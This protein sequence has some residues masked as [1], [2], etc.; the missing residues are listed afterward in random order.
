MRNIFYISYFL[1]PLLLFSCKKETRIEGAVNQSHKLTIAEARNHIKATLPTNRVALARTSQEKTDST[2]LVVNWTAAGQNTSGEYSF[3]EVPIKTEITNVN[4]YGAKQY[5]ENE[6][7]TR[8][9]YSYSTLLIY[10]DSSN[11][12]ASSYIVT[13]LPSIEYIQKHNRPIGRNRI[14]DLSNEFS[15]YIEY[16]DLDGNPK[17][18][19][20]I[21]KGNVTSSMILSNTRP[22]QTKTSSNSKSLAAAA[23]SCQTVCIPIIQTVCVGPGG[24]QGPRDK[25]QICTTTQVGNNCNTVCSGGPTGPPPVGG[26]GGTGG[27]TGGSNNPDV[28]N[29]TTDPCLNKTV[30][31]ILN[32]QDIEGTMKEILDN[33]QSNHDIK[34]SVSD[35]ATTNGKPAQMLNGSLKTYTNP[36]H[37][38]IKRE[39]SAEIRIDNSVLSTISKEGV[40]SLLVH[41][42]LHGYLSYRHID[43]N[44]ETA[45]HSYIAA[46]YLSALSSFLQSKFGV[47]TNDAMALSWAGITDI[48]LYKNANSFQMPDGS[49]ISKRDME[50]KSSNYMGGKDKPNSGTPLCN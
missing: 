30:N 34:L 20:T 40:A 4:L 42:L 25:D 32:N 50:E 17:Q 9:A 26:G 41:E 6:N 47:P 13:Y 12:N 7:A 29:K 35:G 44:K 21:E 18:V 22:I 27:G 2:D 24:G 11:N 45:Q 15:G 39:F 46:N 3:V 37:E 43:Y 1:L 31:N 33:L 14:A 48:D 28:N 16:K 23:A 38:V 19:F 8:V 49:T 36:N 5:N 10:K